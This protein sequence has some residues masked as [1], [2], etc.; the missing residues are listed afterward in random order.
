[1]VVVVTVIVVYCRE[2]IILSCGSGGR[3]GGGGSGSGNDCGGGGR[4]SGR[5]GSG[6]GSGCM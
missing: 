1:M 5:G 6:S 4:V 2:Y 3:V